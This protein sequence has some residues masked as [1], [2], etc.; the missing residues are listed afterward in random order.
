MAFLNA[1]IL[2]I[3]SKCN[4][5]SF[6]IYIT[7]TKIIHEKTSEVTGL[8]VVA[9]KLQY[10]GNVVSSVVLSEALLEFYKFLCKLNEKC[11]LVAHN[12]NFDRPM[13]LAAI[14]KTF[15]SNIFKV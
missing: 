8:R 3:D 2:Q 7:P 6:S 1:E 5:E 15:L 10:H 14:K 13:L 12:C 4:E 9:A 11:I